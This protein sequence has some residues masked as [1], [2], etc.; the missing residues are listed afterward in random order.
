MDNPSPVTQELFDDILAGVWYVCGVSV[1][2]LMSPLRNAATAR[3]RQMC[4]LLLNE[5]LGLSQ[6]EIA[7]RFGRRHPTVNHGL[8]TARAHLEIYTAD[9]LEYNQLKDY[10]Q[11]TIREHR[12]RA[13]CQGCPNWRKYC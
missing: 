7:A 5:L 11:L 4:Y 8:R 3:A 6:T 9:R 10:A 2:D 12:Q 1:E 13:L